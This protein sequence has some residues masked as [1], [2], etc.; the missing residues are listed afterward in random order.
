MILIPLKLPLVCLS[1]LLISHIHSSL[2][3]VPMRLYR[4]LTHKISDVLNSDHIQHAT[5]DAPECLASLRT[6]KNH[7][8]TFP[9]QRSAELLSVLTPY[10][11][12]LSPFLPTKLCYC[13]FMQRAIVLRFKTKSQTHQRIVWH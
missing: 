6:S 7:A 4:L 1:F 10:L 2:C 12:F 8:K 11:Q 9:V 13:C 3:G 5:Q